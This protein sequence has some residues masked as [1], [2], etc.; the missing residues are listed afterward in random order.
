MLSTKGLH[1]G[2]KMLPAPTH[3]N[4]AA[5]GATA[6]LT[7]GVEC[8]SDDWLEALDLLKVIRGLEDRMAAARDG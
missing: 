3:C 5:R 1:G 8:Y 6:L 4:D 2:R 7:S